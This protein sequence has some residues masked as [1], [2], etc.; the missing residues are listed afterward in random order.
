[1]PDALKLN[2]VVH[3]YDFSYH[4]FPE[5]PRSVVDGVDERG[6]GL[7]VGG[8]GGQRAAGGEVEGEGGEEIAQMDKLRVGGAA[9]LD[10]HTSNL[11][12]Q[13]LYCSW[14]AKLV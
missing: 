14:P 12:S 11:L 6:E 1:M 10:A 7:P 4:F 2:N 3:G 8:D 5:C 9:Q 13:L